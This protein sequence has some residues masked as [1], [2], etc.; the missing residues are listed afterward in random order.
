[1]A[2]RY[3]PLI[4]DADGDTQQVGFDGIVMTAGNFTAEIAKMEAVETALQ[5]ILAS[6]IVASSR[7]ANFDM[8]EPR[9]YVRPVNPAAQN[10]TKWLFTFRE[11]ASGLEWRRKVPGAN[12]A[13]ATAQDDIG[14]YVPLDAGDGLALKTALDAFVTHPES[15]FVGELVSIRIFEG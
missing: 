12:Y 7:L 15:G 13:A 8:N 10:H 2:E 11:T 5:A 4:L 14:L 6:K 3:T 1:M 9:P